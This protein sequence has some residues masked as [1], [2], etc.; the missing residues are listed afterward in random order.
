MEEILFLLQPSR[1]PVQVN[2]SFVLSQPCCL[3]F[4]WHASLLV[5]C[6]ALSF[7]NLPHPKILNCLLF[8]EISRTILITHWLLWFPSRPKIPSVYS[9]QVNS[10]TLLY[11]VRMNWILML[12]LLLQL[13]PTCLKISGERSSDSRRR[14]RRGTNRRRLMRWLALEGAYAIHMLFFGSSRW[15]G[16]PACFFIC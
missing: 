2:L 16:T 10:Q 15:R 8:C 11:V 5:V 9:A 7:G 12:F 4:P 14:G 13:W 6:F 1:W 3:Y